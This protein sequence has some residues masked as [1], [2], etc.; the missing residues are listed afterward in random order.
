MNSFILIFVMVFCL[1]GC[2]GDKPLS[3]SK[4]GPANAVVPK[5]SGPHAV[6]KVQPV[7]IKP[8]APVDTR[9]EKPV[10]VRPSAPVDV[11][12]VPANNDK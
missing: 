5:A 1:T 6:K 9:I 2:G 12:V 10:P 4:P 11:G 8:T 3:A 7:V